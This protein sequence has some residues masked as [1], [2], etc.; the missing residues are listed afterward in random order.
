[1][2]SQPKVTHDLSN[3]PAAVLPIYRRAAVEGILGE[4]AEFL[5][6]SLDPDAEGHNP[7]LAKVVA[8]EWDRMNNEATEYLEDNR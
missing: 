2:T 5:M 7:L 6:R 8:F 4:G 3:V 1:M